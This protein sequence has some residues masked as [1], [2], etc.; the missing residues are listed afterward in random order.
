MRSGR[1]I[2]M[3]AVAA[4]LA[5][6]ACT[7][8]RDEPAAPASPEGADRSTAPSAVTE[9]EM[10]ELITLAQQS[11]GR[12]PG[13]W[14]LNEAHNTVL[15]EVRTGNGS[16]VWAV[17]GG[18]EPWV[19]AAARS[20]VWLGSTGKDHVAIVD[21]NETN[22]RYRIRYASLDGGNVR[23]AKTTPQESS[24]LGISG[25][26]LVY[27]LA[28][29]EMVMLFS[30]NVATENT[31]EIG[32]FVDEFPDVHSPTLV[33]EHVVFE[34]S[35]GASRYLLAMSV[36]DGAVV[37]VPQH[38]AN[39][40][41]R[42]VGVA[43]NGDAIFAGGRQGGGYIYT[44]DLT[45]PE[46]AID[47]ID[48]A[49]VELVFMEGTSVRYGNTAGEQRLLDLTTGEET[50]APSRRAEPPGAVAGLEEGHVR[51]IEVLD[52]GNWIVTGWLVDGAEYRALWEFNDQF[53]GT[54]SD[55][56]VF[57][58]GLFEYDPATDELW[59]VSGPPTFSTTSTVSGSGSGPDH[60]LQ[61]EVLDGFV[62]FTT[63]FS[64]AAYDIA[65]NLYA[66]PIPSALEG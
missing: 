16:E 34:A 61:V 3:I 40:R 54:T 38:D 30:W 47:L 5:V 57:V 58:K 26:E 64:G 13:H 50:T 43:P 31:R 65:Y 55:E 2:T 24:V 12:T 21:K 60:V 35:D 23:L 52:N 53:G 25:D 27:A 19:V 49:V 32:S 1:R 29:D 33:G 22:G 39:F 10:A 4:A 44:V 48:D 36:A 9:V 51:L 66:S 8:T 6:G 11:D 37:E 20:D 63:G 15:Y 59:Q 7:S 46:E 45:N 62:V 42:L 41:P 14:W 28:G 17:D 18:G 56:E